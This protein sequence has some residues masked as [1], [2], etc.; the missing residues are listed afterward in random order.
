MESQLEQ[1]DVWT[2]TVSYTHL[3][4]RAAG[5]LDG[6]AVLALDYHVHLGDVYAL[7]LAAQGAGCLLYTSRCV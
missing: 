3:A 6:R 5:Q 7:L 2:Y 1:Q 4:G